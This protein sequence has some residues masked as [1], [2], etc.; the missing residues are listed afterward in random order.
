MAPE[1]VLRRSFG[2]PL[3]RALIFLGLLQQLGHD[4]C[5]LSFPPS[6]GKPPRYWACGCGE[7][8]QIYLFDPRLG[9]ALP[10]V[11]GPVATLAEVR[12][13]DSAALRRLYFDKD[14]HYDVTP[15]MAAAAEVHPAPSLSALAPRMAYLEKELGPKIKVRLAADLGARSVSRKPWPW[16]PDPGRRL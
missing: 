9:M 2:S 12:E 5:L 16:G 4:G 8:G 11:A 15:E 14:T 10:G 1:F 7:D 3:A 6:S 13:K